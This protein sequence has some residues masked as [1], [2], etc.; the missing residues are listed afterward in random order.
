MQDFHGNEV[1]CMLC[2][3][4]NAEVLNHR[5]GPAWWRCILTHRRDGSEV[6][7]PFLFLI[8]LIQCNDCKEHFCSIDVPRD[9]AHWRTY[10][11]WEPEFGQPMSDD[12]ID[13]L[14]RKNRQ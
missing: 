11:I 7:P 6:V 13:K 10:P 4:R 9:E 5:E 2:G 8:G 3:S 12:E 1:D 14:L